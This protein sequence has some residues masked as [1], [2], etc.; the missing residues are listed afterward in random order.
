MSLE[1]LLGAVKTAKKYTW[2]LADELALRQYTKL[3]KQLEAQGID[4]RF[5]AGT[6]AIGNIALFSSVPLIMDTLG[7]KNDVVNFMNN[8]PKS[9]RAIVEVVGST[10]LLSLTHDIFDTFYRMVSSRS[11]DSGAIAEDKLLYFSRGVQ[12]VVRLPWLLYG[13]LDFYK[14]AERGLQRGI[15]NSNYIDYLILANGLLFFSLAS[16]MYIKDSDPKLLDKQPMWKE[17]FDFLKGK[18]KSLVPLPSPTPQ[19][20]PYIE[21]IIQ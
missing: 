3:T 9:S 10:Y 4:R 19:H 11:H 17:A 6:I 16:S 8:I 21:T 2:D 14:L 7:Y 20:A 1:S 5:V 15:T 18:A 12:R 13:L